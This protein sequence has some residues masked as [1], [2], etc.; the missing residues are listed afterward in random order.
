MSA[1][2]PA[3]MGFYED[4]EEGAGFLNSLNLILSPKIITRNLV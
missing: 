2:T 4:T 1:K 3:T